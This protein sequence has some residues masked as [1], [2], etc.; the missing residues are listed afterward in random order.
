MKKILMMGIAL[1]AAVVF[2]QGKTLSLADA[3]AK[4]DEAVNDPAVMTELVS[5]LSP[6]DQ[7]KFLAMVNAA[8][9]SPNFPGS[10][11]DKALAYVSVNAAAMQGAAPGNLAAMLAETYAT[12]PPEALPA[13]NERFAGDLFNRSSNPSMSDAAVVHAVENSM[14]AITERNASSDNAGVRDTFAALMFLSASNGQPASLRD[15]IVETLP[16]EVRATA[17]VEWMPAALG[18]NQVQ[19]YE[20]MLG[21]ADAGEAYSP[22]LVVR[23][24]GS[25]MLDSMLGDLVSEG[26]P[27]YDAA[28]IAVELDT[29]TGG[30]G[31]V[32]AADSVPRTTD[33]SEPWYPGE[34]R[35]YDG[36]TIGGK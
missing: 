27:V 6:A 2:A 28:L 11:A 24:A 19:S 29:R 31:S 21:A 8:I 33:P 10:P 5:Q 14:K 12:V 35:G 15:T 30:A 7:V 32:G 9:G 34:S 18:E 23:V 25:Q 17:N 36:Q 26:T 4:I 16:A 22:E 3:S 1:V 20:P 13:V